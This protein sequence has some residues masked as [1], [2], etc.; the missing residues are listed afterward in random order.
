MKK[1]TS[2]N[3][4][5]FTLFI[6][7]FGSLFFMET[8]FRLFSSDTIFTFIYLRVIVFDFLTSLIISFVLSFIDYKLSKKILLVIFFVL[9]IYSIFQLTYLNY[10]HRFFTMQDSTYGVDKVIAFGIDFILSINIFHLMIFIPWLIILF[11]TKHWNFN[12]SPLKIKR[13]IIGSICIIIIHTLSI[14]LLFIGNDPE[15]LNTPYEIYTKVDHSSEAV[16]QIGIFRFLDRDLINFFNP[17]EE[18]IVI[19]NIDTDN[20]PIE[21]P[22]VTDNSRNIDDTTWNTIIAQE[23]NEDMLTID[24]YLINQEIPD[25]NDMTGVFAGKNLILIMVEAFDYMAID[26]ELTPT[27]YKLVQESWFFDNFYSP[28]YSCAT[29]Q[30]EFAGLTS[31][32]PEP[33]NCT[34][35]SYA[36]NDYYESIFNL[37]NAKDYYSSSYHNWTDQYYNRVEAHKS[38]YSDHFY[39]YD[40]LPFDTIQGWQSDHELFELA[41]PYFLDE[42]QFF[43][44]IITSSTHFPYDV[45]STLGNRYM[46]VINEIRPDYPIEV[47]RYISKAMELDKGIAYLIETLSE[48]GKL[49]D[50]VIIL[51]GDHHPLRM[52][53]TNFVKYSYGDNDRSTIFGQ[54]LTPF[55]IYNS[56]ITANT[57]K[58][59][60]S[61]V[62]IT[63][64]IANLFD[65]NYDPRLYIGNDYFSDNEKTVYFANGSW[66][67]SDGYY[68]ANKSQFEPFTDAEIDIDAL[69]TI[70]T[71]IKNRFNISK[72]IYKTDYFHYRHE[73]VFPTILTQ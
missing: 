13:V 10:M 19:V 14:C 3:K 6:I 23:T 7:T 42:D 20:D 30:S 51:Y 35:N 12:K 50:T 47:K 16:H 26:E 8:V 66:L 22:I 25:T 65:L 43:S 60:M 27:L 58:K 18:E 31:L 52:D 4:Y 34:I 57:F 38:M 21:E 46:D 39:N 1:E 64:T 11:K 68:N 54:S 37:F 67:D 15:Q 48:A 5:F 59:P 71:T 69:N 17:T 36:S 40:E 53:V 32:A 56:T 9:A 49:D 28:Q 63:P 62:D 45:D 29:G 61:T 44:F 2:A 73:I 72:L 70:N 33:S 55:I 41:L 24:Q